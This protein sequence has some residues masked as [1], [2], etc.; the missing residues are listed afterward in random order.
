MQSISDPHRLSMIYFMKNTFC[1]FY[2]SQHLVILNIIRMDLSSLRCLYIV[3]SVSH[4][5]FCFY[6]SSIRLIFSKYFL[7]AY[8]I[9][10]R[11]GE[12]KVFWIMSKTFTGKGLICPQ[13]LLCNWV[14]LGESGFPANEAR[15]D[16]TKH[17]SCVSYVLSVIGG[18]LN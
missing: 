8:K 14:L 3:P 16:N 17:L 10:L 11:R 5:E 15:T 13:E 18:F 2:T 12:E 9:I 6:P 1:V 7:Q 4:G